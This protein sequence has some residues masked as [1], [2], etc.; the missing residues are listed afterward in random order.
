MKKRYV[1]YIV[2]LFIVLIPLV[3][4][5]A[6]H[7]MPVPNGVSYESEV[8]QTDD[9]N[10]LYDITLM[11]AEGES[12]SKQQIIDE[13]YQ[14]IDEA[15]DFLVIDM[16]LFNDDYN[17]ET[18]DFPTLSQ[19]L[20]NKLI[21]KKNKNPDLEIVFITDPINTFYGTYTPDHLAALEEAGINLI[22][23]D[24]S[25]LRDSN[26]I[27]SGVY[28]SYLQHFGT[29]KE[30]WLTNVLRPDGP[31][32][33]IRS[34]IQMLNF[35]ANH[36]KVVINE[37]DVLVTSLNPHD[38]SAH[39][40]NIALKTSGPIIEEFLDS[41]RA[42]VNFSGGDTRIFSD[43]KDG[44]E[45]EDETGEYK[46]KFMTE[47]KI[48]ENILT[49]IDE[50]DSEDHLK[51][52]LFYLS[53]RD[54]IEALK[55]AVDRDV[56]VKLILDINK[57]A[58]GNEKNG[59]PNKPVADELMSYENP[60]EIRWY[61]SSGEQY[62]S[63]FIMLEAEDEVIFNGGSANFT[64]RNLDDYNLETNMM[65]TAP[66]GSDF[67]SHV[68]TYYDTLWNNDGAEYTL[69]YEEEA[70]DSLGKNILYRIQEF[71]GLSTF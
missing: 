70:E 63:K 38:A 64:R 2:L 15:E 9:V 33:N 22:Y 57:D 50:A 1:L 29:S 24:L 20:A 8:Y 36:R 44:L 62:H 16:F 42:V 65:V 43:F 30:A 12:Q 69:D 58:F 6:R 55:S 47:G 23:T 3:V 59:V 5:T 21:E 60:P 4:M 53:D 31:E 14:M 13:I 26:S 34:Y 68:T 71:F 17:H 27:Y 45:A 46:V 39:H 11:N 37:K 41:E 48:K 40:S 32:V 49:M 67:S 35:K 28:R 10:F 7:F 18:L 61:K 52:G 19:D 54:V 51:L 25:K 56:N 66:K